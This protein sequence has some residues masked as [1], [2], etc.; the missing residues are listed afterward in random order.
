MRHPLRD[1]VVVVPGILGSRLERA[2]RPIWGG[3]GVAAALLDPEGTLGLCGDGFAPEPDVV[4][5]GLIG[6]LAQF[7]GLSKI[8]AYDRLVDGLLAQ[9]QLDKANFVTFP[10]DWRLSCRVNAK[11]L[12]CR[13]WPVLDAR[14]R[15]HPGAGFVFIC[16]SMGGLIVQHFTDVLGGAA[17]THEVVTLGTPFRGAA[18]AFEVIS[19]GWPARLPGIRSRF[20][21]LAQRL[22]SVYE[23]LPRYRAI[24][25]GS[26]RRLL[27]PADLA[28]G[29]SFALFEQAEVFHNA[30][31]LPGPRPYGRTVVAGVLQPTA[32]FARLEAGQVRILKRWKREDGTV[33]DE[34]G[35]GTVPRQS[36]APPEWRDDRHAVPFPHTHIGLPTT[37]AVLRTLRHVLTATPRAE[38]AGERAKLA[39][40]VPDLVEAGTGVEVRCEIAEGDRGVPL[41]VCAEPVDGRRPPVTQS[42][43]DHDGQ[44]IA[45][46]D[47][48]SP[49]DY[50]VSVSP[51][52]PMP[53]VRP[54]WDAL[55]VV[56]PALEAAGPARLTET[57]SLSP[58]R[59]HG[60]V[61]SEGPHETYSDPH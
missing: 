25:D 31:D 48:L 38:Q 57:D 60:G 2:R 29:A 51:A 46:F 59:G 22:P 42:P 54:V 4:A 35:D 36:F 9:F 20:R 1:V 23:L 13:I 39:I 12:A 41:L 44:L 24:V 7:P 28:P 3:A 6:R 47:G 19:R 10:Y 37:G 61:E 33:L 27:A 40:D 52:V 43:R 15:T 8:D 32:Q 21:R 18:K 5:T 53:D 56:D 14:R 58:H 50:R 49:G 30:L 55:T 11:Q 17:D 34:R 26:E 16:H 45:R